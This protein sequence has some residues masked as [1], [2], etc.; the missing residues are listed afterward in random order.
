MKVVGPR[1][2]VRRTRTG[3]VRGLPL[4]GNGLFF[5]PSY[6]PYAAAAYAG[7]TLIPRPATRR[8]RLDHVDRYC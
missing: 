7:V 5:V 1:P 6:P 4:A 3:R 2:I 8:H